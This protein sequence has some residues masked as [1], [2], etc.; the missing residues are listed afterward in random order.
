MDDFGGDAMKASDLIAELPRLVG[1]YGDL[2]VV[3][4]D[5]SKSVREVRPYDARG[6]SSKSDNVEFCLHG[7]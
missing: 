4:D 3:F 7:F 2:P 1:L 5:D 6:N